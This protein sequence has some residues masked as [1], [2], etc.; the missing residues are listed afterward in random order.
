MFFLA[1]IYL[2]SDCMGYT[3]RYREFLGNR[4]RIG[5][6]RP[7]PDAGNKSFYTGKKTIVLFCQKASA[8][9]L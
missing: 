5:I 3:V 7:W 9:F 8:K 1:G 2:F 6:K 4:F